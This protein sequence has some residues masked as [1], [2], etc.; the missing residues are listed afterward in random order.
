MS[1]LFHDILASVLGA[2]VLVTLIVLGLYFWKPL[3]VIGTLLLTI[4]VVRKSLQNTEGSDDFTAP[5]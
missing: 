3:A 2:A 1:E 4:A 5:Y